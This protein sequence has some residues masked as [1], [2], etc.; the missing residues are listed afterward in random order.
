ME[1]PTTL[2]RRLTPLGSPVYARVWRA[3]PPIPEHKIAGWVEFAPQP[4]PEADLIRDKK[5]YIKPMPKAQKK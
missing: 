1:T 4:I 5:A 2:N 3:V